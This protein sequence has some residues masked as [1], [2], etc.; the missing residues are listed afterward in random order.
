ELSGKFWG[1]IPS[2]LGQLSNLE[3]L[4]ISNLCNLRD[5]I[6][7]SIPAS[8][9][10]LTK[11]QNLRLDGH[12]SLTG[13]IPPELGAL[14]ELQEI[15]LQCNSL[16]GEIPLELGQLQSLVNLNFAGNQL[17]GVL[18][19]P[20]LESMQKRYEENAALSVGPTPEKFNY[21]DWFS[22]N[23]NCFNSN[24]PGKCDGFNTTIP[25]E[26][27]STISTSTS[28]STILSSL[29][30]SKTSSFSR[31]S[32][33]IITSPIQFKPTILPSTTRK[34]LLST[35]V[36]PVSPSASTP[37]ANT[38]TTS[39][40]AELPAATENAES[41]DQEEPTTENDSSDVVETRQTNDQDVPR[42]VPPEEGMATEER[43]HHANGS[44]HL[45]MTQITL[46][47]SDYLEE[48]E[49]DDTRSET[50]NSEGKK[51]NIRKKNERSSP[52]FES[53]EDEEDISLPPVTHK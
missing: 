29:L 9:G 16:T 3:T 2:E 15:S 25:T 50:M 53:D 33:P 39:T 44:G 22:V 14:S 17:S 11:L 27:A 7:G 36:I 28:S 47:T 21:P 46:P 40:S 13:S 19:G 51:H 37:Q 5:L 31:T 24:F 38:A 4:I 1:E 49:Q 32:S 20:F 8:F 12:A 10:R 23:E 41:S 35:S 26:S 30:A 52:G 18:P 45:F 34:S 48:E 43:T 42:A 6:E